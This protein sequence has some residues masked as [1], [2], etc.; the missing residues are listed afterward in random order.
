MTRSKG[1]EVQCEYLASQN[2]S[3]DVKVWN[4][5]RRKLQTD[6]DR[7]WYGGSEKLEK[8][9]EMDGRPSDNSDK[10]AALSEDRKY[11]SNA[12]PS[13]TMTS[14][15]RTD[16]TFIRVNGSMLVQKYDIKAGN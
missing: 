15:N 12:N 4:L 11:V 16:A 1:S 7:T 5:R 10:R 2:I 13:V 14:A 9:S 8:A 6:K 3:Y